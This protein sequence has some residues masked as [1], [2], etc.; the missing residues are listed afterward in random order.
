MKNLEKQEAE[1]ERLMQIIAQSAGL[2]K[3]VCGVCNGAAHALALV[4]NTNST[5]QKYFIYFFI[6]ELITILFV[7]FINLLSFIIFQFD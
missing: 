7:F 2:V 4:H 3:L 6:I 5:T 1:L